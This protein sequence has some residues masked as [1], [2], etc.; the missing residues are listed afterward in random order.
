MDLVKIEIEQI[1]N[2]G[3]ARGGSFPVDP[4]RFG[5]PFPIHDMHISTLLPGH[6]RGDHYHV[7]RNEILIVSPGVRWTLFFD[8]GPDTV[9]EKLEFD[10]ST[11]VVMSVPPLVSHA[12]RND[13]DGALHIIGLTDG[14]YDPTAPDAFTRKVTSQ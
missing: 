1:A 8:A 9:P 6:I 14:P 4:S 10:G 2:S 7:K 11:A 5:S 12:I 13:G 3:D